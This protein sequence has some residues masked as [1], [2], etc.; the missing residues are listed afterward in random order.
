MQMHQIDRI[1]E[2]LPFLY[3]SPEIQVGDPV[4]HPENTRRLPTPYEFFGLR[5]RDPC[6][7]EDFNV[8]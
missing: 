1:I 2:L 3:P 7:D 6:V 4:Q 8:R 5:G